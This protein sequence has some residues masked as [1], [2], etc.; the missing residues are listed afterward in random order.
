MSYNLKK[1]KS[2]I[3][4]IDKLNSDD[5]MKK[6]NIDEST[7]E[8]LLDNGKYH[9][10]KWFSL[11]S[12]FLD[13]NPSTSEILDCF[14]GHQGMFELIKM[15]DDI[16]TQD[17]LTSKYTYKYKQK[18]C[19]DKFME[20]LKNPPYWGMLIAPTGWGKSFMHLL[21]I[22]AYMKVYNDMNIVF[23]T[24]RKELLEDQYSDM[25]TK[26]NALKSSDMFPQINVKIVSHVDYA[27]YKSL[28]KSTNSRKIIII[29][30]DKIIKDKKKCINWKKIGFVIFD[31]MHWTGSNEI[32]KAMKY[33]K[34]EGVKFCIGSSATPM[35]RHY[36][37][38]KNIKEL[39]EGNILTEI[40]YVE[41]WENKVIVPVH[42]VM[43][44]IS[45]YD[46]VV[47]YDSDDEDKEEKCKK[48]MIK[49]QPD[50]K[51]RIIKTLR[52]Y[53][54]KDKNKKAIL[55]FS[56]RISLLEWYE[57]IIDNKYFRSYNKYVSYSVSSS[58]S[59][60]SNNRVIQMMRKLNISNTDGLKTFKEQNSKSLMFVVFRGTEGFDDPRV[61]VCADMDFRHNRSINLTLQKMGRAQRLFTGKDIGYYL[62]FIPS[63]SDEEVKKEIV[64]A[65]T[66]YLKYVG[67]SSGDIINA[68]TKKG[69]KND[70]VQI[71]KMFSVDDTIEFTYDDMLNEIKKNELNERGLSLHKFVNMLKLHK[72]TNHGS[73]HKFIETEKG[74]KLE[75]P[76]DYGM[77]KDFTWDMVASKDKYYSKEE[78]IPCLCDLSKK[79]KKQLDVMDDNEE[80]LQFLIKHDNRV[81]EDLPWLHYDL[82]KDLFSFIFNVS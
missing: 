26:I 82:R 71:I 27:D 23:I 15:T 76:Y 18:E 30:S 78:I 49:F 31:E 13:T 35:R 48:R 21:L 52:K 81:P 69:E 38:Q 16:I 80:I 45:E 74:K 1:L 43:I 9:N 55:F 19:Y 12:K 10:S 39:M 8:Y 11:L 66:N 46:E 64:N 37:N 32:F 24:K 63:G 42:T 40:S 68:D 65:C 44:K 5:L 33:I 70:V 20:I 67:M 79:Y 36:E 6:Y 47:S 75:L 53:L 50:G 2:I 54:E 57:F 60:K 62:R 14:D 17:I 34:D 56:T 28:N 4:N 41:A 51:K 61:S 73:Y 22:G 25:E 58:S 77:F 72:I 59:S 7:A 3:K 29:N